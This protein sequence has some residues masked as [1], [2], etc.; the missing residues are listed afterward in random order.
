MGMTEGQ[1]DE[2]NLNEVPVEIVGIIYIYNPPDLAKVG[3]GTAQE[4][5]QA[6]PGAPGGQM[7]PGPGMQPTPP[8]TETNAAPAA[9][10]QA[11]PAAPATPSGTP[12]APV[13]P[14][15]EPAVPPGTPA[16]P[17]TPMGAPP[18]AATGEQ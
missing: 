16:A 13:T 18:A 10:P 1:S 11:T 9:V 8:G 12:A 6:M 2:V 7:E 17:G 5:D 4:T 3:T 14:L 15:G